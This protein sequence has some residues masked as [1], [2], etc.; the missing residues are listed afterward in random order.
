M[1]L[2]VTVCPQFCQYKQ[3]N[4]CHQNNTSAQ[5]AAIRLLTLYG[6]LKPQSTIIQQYGDGWAVDCYIW[7]SE[8]GP[9][10][11]VAPPVPYSLYQ[12]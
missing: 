1:S 7:Y 6:T 3:M 11:A 8:E 2:V 12:T 10:R 4:T 9:G 5:Y